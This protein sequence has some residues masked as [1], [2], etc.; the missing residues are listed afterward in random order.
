M[1]TLKDG[2][3][4]ALG[5]IALGTAVVGWFR[6][7]RPRWQAW[8]QRRKDKDTVLLGRPA[9]PA[10]LITGAPAREAIPSIGQQMT[11]VLKQ[12]E[13]VME[14][15]NSMHHELHPNSGNSL[16]DT[17]DRTERTVTAMSARLADGDQRFDAIDAHLSRIDEVLAGELSVATDTVANA[18]EASRVALE[19]IDTAL[20]S[21]PPR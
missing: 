17:A 1:T 21:E 5:L 4:L 12:L 2:I 7:G 14:L 11:F 10:N 9:V 6:W 8:T 16:R 15:A 20:R 19:V 18:A 3:A 13:H